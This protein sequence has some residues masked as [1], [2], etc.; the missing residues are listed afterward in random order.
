M[1]AKTLSA[2]AMLKMR[3]NKFKRALRMAAIIRA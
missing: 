1:L 2:P 3:G